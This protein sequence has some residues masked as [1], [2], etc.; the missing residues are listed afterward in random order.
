MSGSV[1]VPELGFMAWDGSI[2]TYT[3]TMVIQ[4]INVVTLAGFA[5]QNQNKLVH[6]NSCGLLAKGIYNMM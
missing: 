6:G 2:Y 1:A 3:G 4:V 5:C